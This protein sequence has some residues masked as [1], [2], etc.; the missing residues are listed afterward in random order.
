[1]AKSIP[2]T[3]PNENKCATREKGTVTR[4]QTGISGLD[5]MTKG[6]FP[7]GSAVMVR[8]GTGTCKTNLCLQ[9]LYMG[10]AKYKEPGVMISFAES[11]EQI[12]QHAHCFGWDLHELAE[13]NMFTIIRYA[14]HEVMKV[15][16]EGG[17]SIRDTIESLGAKRVVIDSI[18]AYEML[19]E[20][21]Y[22]AN[23]SVLNLFEM[24]RSWN[25]TTIVT[26]ESPVEPKQM[27]KGR[28][29]FLSD[30]VIHMYNLRSGQTRVRALEII[31][32]RDTDHTNQVKTFKLT[33]KGIVIGKELKNVSKF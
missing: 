12:C 6:G 33:D 13:K 27:H 23:E 4:I 15:M 26:S 5:E 1:M 32:M 29:G 25:A 8:G 24:F 31:K 11:K 19:F 17:G 9:Y 7:C 22:Q 30:G 3:K 20:K 18:T 10:A 14:P 16:E 2:R 28:S 21:R